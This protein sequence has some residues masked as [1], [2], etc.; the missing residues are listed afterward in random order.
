M[1]S[2]NQSNVLT[3]PGE[4]IFS[5][6]AIKLTLE[7]RAR[8]VQKFGLVQDMS[9]PEFMSL[10]AEEVGEAAQV[11]NDLHWS[12]T[13]DDDLVK[14]RLLGLREEL[15]QVAALAIQAMEAVERELEAQ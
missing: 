2:T 5:M 7:E 14:R 15:S 13:E 1:Q 10:I 3:L 9:Y 6:S 8:Q 12:R 11:A 4:L